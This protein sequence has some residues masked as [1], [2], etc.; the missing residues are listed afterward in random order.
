[1]RFKIDLPEGFAEKQQYY[2]QLSD[3]DDDDKPE[4][5]TKGLHSASS[6]LKGG[7][8]GKKKG[9]GGSG[10]GASTK[11][12]AT[13]RH[14]R[15][16]MRERPQSAKHFRTIAL[17]DPEIKVHYRHINYRRMP[18]TEEQEKWVDEREIARS[19][20]SDE[21]AKQL[22][23]TFQAKND[24][25][26]DKDKGGKD[27][28]DAKKKDD[29]KKDGKGGKHGA[30]GTTDGNH[31]QKNKYKSASQFMSVNFP[32]FEDNE[33]FERM[34]PMRKIQLLEVAEIAETFKDYNLNIKEA[35]LKKALIIPQDK[36][37]AVCLENLRDEKE[38]LMMNPN[39]PEYW[40]KVVMKA[41]S[42]KGKKKKK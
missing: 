41:S 14:E 36:P 31:E 12:E 22:V 13:F 38:G 6:T 2:M 29:K 26:K 33:H 42:K 28:K 32:N 21:V 10:A 27:K 30:D 35:V 4:R 19:K 1:M 20:K 9:G 39:P 40:R 24:K 15:P 11:V 7:A 5:T 17:N 34:A 37:E 3:S 18:L 23:E 8:G 25:K 16:I